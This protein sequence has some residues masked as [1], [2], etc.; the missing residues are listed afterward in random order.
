MVDFFWIISFY[1]VFFDSRNFCNKLIIFITL[2]LLYKTDKSWLLKRFFSSEKNVT[3]EDFPVKD[4]WNIEKNIL[5]TAISFPFPKK[6]NNLYWNE[7]YQLCFVEV[8]FLKTIEFGM[9]FR[10][11][12]NCLHMRPGPTGEVPCVRGLSKES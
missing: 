4:Y 11:K 9:S 6:L 10:V 2:V 8:P 3:L 12:A 5:N 1:H 7:I